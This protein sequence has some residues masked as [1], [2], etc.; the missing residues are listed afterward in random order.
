MLALLVLGVLGIF[1]VLMFGTSP[2]PRGHGTHEQLGMTP[3]SWP[4]VH[5]MPCMTCGVTTSASL[6]LHGRPIAAFLTQ[7]FGMLLTL[8]ALLFIALS[9]SHLVR[10]E[11][12]ASRVAFWPWPKILI[13]WVLLLLGAW[14]YKIQTFLP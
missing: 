14:Y 7:P 13:F 2:D 8:T 6:L 9:I 1:G 11:C 10:G 12:L 3:C 5:G 4:R